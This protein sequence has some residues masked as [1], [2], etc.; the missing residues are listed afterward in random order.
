MVAQPNL[1]HLAALLET[2]YPFI[3]HRA[4]VAIVTADSRSGINTDIFNDNSTISYNIAVV[5]GRS[6]SAGLL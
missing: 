5:A 2:I 4:L 6:Q 3:S 1:I